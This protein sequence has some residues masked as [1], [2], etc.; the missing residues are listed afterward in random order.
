MTEIPQSIALALEQYFGA[1]IASLNP[2]QFGFT[3]AIRGVLEFANT[4]RA[5]VKCATDTETESWLAT[6]RTMY[7]HFDANSF[8]R[9]PKLLHVIE[10]KGSDFSAL[11]LQ[12]LSACAVA[13]PWSETRVQSVLNTL[14]VVS[15]LSPPQGLPKLSANADFA[16]AWQKIAA[17]LDAVVALDV[18]NRAWWIRHAP[19]LTSLDGARILEGDALLHLDVRSDNMAFR[20]NGECVLFDWNWACIGNPRAEIAGWLPSLALEGGT[21]PIALQ[22]RCREQIFLMFGFLLHAATRPNIP[23]APMLREFQRKQALALRPLVD[24]LL[25]Y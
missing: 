18:I 6:E 19:T 25:D 9:A 12:D 4:K 20:E 14:E 13:P 5:F 22:H 15:A 3:A 7:T 1:P 23:K 24:Q 17:A 11:A 2:A 16:R 8:S 21:L 10:A